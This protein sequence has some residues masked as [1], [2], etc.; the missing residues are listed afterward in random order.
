MPGLGE[1][2]YPGYEP[3]SAEVKYYDGYEDE[4]LD[5]EDWTQ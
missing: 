1:D 5:Y 4:D 3:L 2:D